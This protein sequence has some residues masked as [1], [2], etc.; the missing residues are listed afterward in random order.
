M[1]SD[2]T[3][4]GEAGRDA[5]ME[6][7]RKGE[8]E[9]RAATAAAARTRAAFPFREKLALALA[10]IGNRLHCGL[11]KHGEGEPTAEK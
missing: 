8:K 7:W 9:S 3:R 6:K 4:A 10:L 2:S 1:E 11:G 5:A